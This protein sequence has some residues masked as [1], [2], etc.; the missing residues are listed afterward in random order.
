M[1]KMLKKVFSTFLIYDENLPEIP[2]NYQWFLTE[3][4]QIAGICKNELSEKDVAILSAFLTPYNLNI[5]KP[6]EQELIWKERIQ[7]SSS[8]EEPNEGFRFVYFHFNKNQIEPA[9]F[10]TTIQEFFSRPISILWENE[11]EGIIIQQKEALSAEQISYVQISDTLM[12]DLYVKIKFIVGPFLNQ[13]TGLREYHSALVQSA[14]YAFTYTDKS[15]ITYVDAIPF[16]FVEHTAAD[17]RKQLGTFV[18]KEFRNDEDFLQM[19]RTFI[20]CNLNISVAAKKLYMHRNSLQYRIDKFQ[21]K[22]GVDLRQFD[23]A[24]T[25]YLALLAIMHKDEA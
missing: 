23:Q 16:I 13:F 1:Q 4:N 24:V 25:V 10:K 6:T 3:T 2:D 5:P 22:T 8:T 21:E 14:A 20:H 12:S 7:S 18:L 17:Q 15:V 11:H 9:I 19:I